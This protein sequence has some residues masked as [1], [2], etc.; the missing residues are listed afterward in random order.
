MID[1]KVHRGGDFYEKLSG[2]Q[3][4]KNATDLDPG[5]IHARHLC[6]RGKHAKLKLCV[7]NI[8]SNKLITEVNFRNLFKVGCYYSI[9]R[10]IACRYVVTVKNGRAIAQAVSL[11]LPTVA[12][13]VRSQVR[14]CG[15]CGGQSGT[16]ARFLE[17][18]RFPPP[19][20]IPPT[21]PHPS[22]IVRGG[23]IG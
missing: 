23:T 7:P 6:S 18:L 9:R 20:L 5:I 4:P 13:R 21:T 1:I 11:R 3:R 17:V 2:F 12:A 22:S 19:I 15:T 16:G 10:P 14:S 8:R